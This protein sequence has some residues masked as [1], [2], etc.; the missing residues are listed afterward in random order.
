VDKTKPRRL[1]Y[2]VF[3]IPVQRVVHIATFSLLMSLI[4][5]E[6]RLKEAEIDK[7]CGDSWHDL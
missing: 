3:R 7:N 1:K 2:T 5:L 6:Y 4:P